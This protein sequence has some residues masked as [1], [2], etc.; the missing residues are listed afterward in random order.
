MTLEFPR[1]E[2]L[3]VRQ[4]PEQQPPSAHS[5]GAPQLLHAA[6][7]SQP[8]CSCRFVPFIVAL[9]AITNRNRFAMRFLST[10]WRTL[11]AWLKRCLCCCWR[12]RA[13]FIDEKTDCVELRTTEDETRNAHLLPATVVAEVSADALDPDSGHR[14]SIDDE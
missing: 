1:R 6:S 10:V 5:Y 7:S 3:R 4:L 14:S 8:S 11:K 13:R 2:E 9:L 12:P